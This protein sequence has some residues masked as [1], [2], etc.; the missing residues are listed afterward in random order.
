M[1][2]DEHPHALV[3]M[4][5]CVYVCVPASKASS[6]WLDSLPRFNHIFVGPLVDPI[7]KK[8]KGGEVAYHSFNE[9]FWLSLKGCIAPGNMTGRQ[10]GE[11]EMI[12]YQVRK[13]KK[14]EKSVKIQKMCRSIIRASSRAPGGALCVWEAVRPKEEISRVWGKWTW[15]NSRWT[16][17]WIR[18]AKR[19]KLSS[20]M[21]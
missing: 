13:K 14:K 4:R 2:Q 10:M 17:D 8:C 1:L 5:V 11:D 7:S 20:K 18:G 15:W 12:R 3:S 6:E 19:H 9:F 16:K 21:L